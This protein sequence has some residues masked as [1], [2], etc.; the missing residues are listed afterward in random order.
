MPAARKGTYRML[1]HED[2]QKNPRPVIGWLVMIFGQQFS[3]R[4][5]GKSFSRDIQ[6]SGGKVI[7]I[8]LTR[9]KNAGKK[10]RKSGR[11][12]IPAVGRRMNSRTKRGYFM[13]KVVIITCFEN[14]KRVPA[15]DFYYAGHQSAAYIHDEHEYI[16]TF[17]N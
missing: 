12:S 16:G 8:Q 10:S 15:G 11:V 2:S 4:A 3:I 6:G 14:G 1:Q 7:R 9:T 5:N 13:T 17:L